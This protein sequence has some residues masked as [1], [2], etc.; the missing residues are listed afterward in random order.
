M[1]SCTLC[2]I[3]NSDTPMF[4]AID[5]INL[6]GSLPIMALISPMNLFLFYQNNQSLVSKQ[7]YLHNHHWTHLNLFKFTALID[8]LNT[9]KSLCWSFQ[10]ECQ[11]V[12]HAIYKF[13]EELIAS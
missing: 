6:L 11:E 13:L 10:F 9:L 2:L 7:L 1:S 12:H 5:M 4:L 8:I 3:R